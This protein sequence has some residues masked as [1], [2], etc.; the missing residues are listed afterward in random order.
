MAT[1]HFTPQLERFVHAPVVEAAG[2]TVAEV[3]AAVFTDHPA[4]KS[5]VVDGQGALRKHVALFIDGVQIRDRR[6][7]SDA[8]D[9][10]SEIYIFQALSGG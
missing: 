7:L 4:L 10:K 6:H 2:A 1:V 9:A 8:V 5:Y 3:L